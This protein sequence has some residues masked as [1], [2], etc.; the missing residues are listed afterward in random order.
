MYCLIMHVCE[1]DKL[2]TI[3]VSDIIKSTYLDCQQH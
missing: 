3:S 1:Y 2:A